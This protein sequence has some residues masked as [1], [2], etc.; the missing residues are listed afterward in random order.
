MPDWAVFVACV[1]NV[2]ALKPVASR[3]GFY[4]DDQLEATRAA[5]GEAIRDY[6]IG[7]SKTDPDR[8]T[9]LI[10]LHHTAIRSLASEDE[11]CFRVFG[12]YLPFE[13]SLGRMTLGDY[14]ARQ[15]VVRYVATRDEFRQIA[16]VAAAQD[17]CVINAGYAFD[18]ELMR[19]L[20]HCEPEAD[21]EAIGASD[22][23]QEF[24]EL[25]LDERDQ[26]MDLVRLADLVLQPYR[27][28]AEI[29]RYKPEEL[30]ALFTANPQAEFLRQAEQ[31]RDQAEGM[32]ADLIG[33]VSSEATLSANAQLCLNYANPLIQRLTQVTD[34]DAIR[35]AVEMLYVH[36]LLMGHHPLSTRETQL[37]QRGMLGL[38]E[39][40]ISGSSDDE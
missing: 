36:A 26:A 30:P 10:D 25:T 24:E 22:L 16:Q 29:R 14:R 18:G 9:A 1:A 19:M 2:R 34:R 8:L 27:C 12:P 17:L 31:T 38:I 21:V 7:L 4:E 33:S 32:W 39:R 6:L 3:E 37:I 35:E 13:T 11:D 23:S 28:G 5:L 20:R 15:D 40:S